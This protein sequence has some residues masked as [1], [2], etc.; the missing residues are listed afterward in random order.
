MLGRVTE[1][2]AENELNAFLTGK[3]V[4]LSEVTVTVLVFDWR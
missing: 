1:V 4:S 2:R 3:V